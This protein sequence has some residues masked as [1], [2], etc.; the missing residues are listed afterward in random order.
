MKSVD[1]LKSMAYEID[2][3][4]HL[5]SPGALSPFRFD[6]GP[7][8]SNLLPRLMKTILFHLYAEL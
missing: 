3:G 8:T 7:C 4:G 5:K 6:S 1:L 2:S